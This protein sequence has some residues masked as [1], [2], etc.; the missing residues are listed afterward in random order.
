METKRLTSK[1]LADKLGGACDY[2]PGFIPYV[3]I[4][5]T[6]RSGVRSIQP[7]DKDIYC[8]ARRHGTG[9]RKIDDPAEVERIVE[10]WDKQSGS[11]FETALMNLF[12]IADEDML[13]RLALIF[14]E[15]VNAWEGWK[16]H[17]LRYQQGDEA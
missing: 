12:C 15:A 8:M 3:Y 13:T 5:R 4:C 7:P 14:P 11:Q 1:Q 6:H 16:G 10:F 2:T 17:R 9:Y